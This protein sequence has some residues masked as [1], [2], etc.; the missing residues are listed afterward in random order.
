MITV[1]IIGILAAIAIP[2]FQRYLERSRYSEAHTMVSQITTSAKTYFTTNQKNCANISNC[3]EPWHQNSSRSAGMTVEWKNKV[4]PG[5]NT[6]FNT[7]GGN[8]PPQG[9]GKYKP[10]P[11]AS[12]YA[13][14]I[15]NALNLQLNDPLYFKYIHQ[16]SGSGSQAT[17]TV[18][19]RADFDPSSSDVHTHR[20]VL[21]VESG[22][23]VERPPVT[24]HSGE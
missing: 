1:A 5:A 12:S 16:P 11:S 19:A 15:A 8:P 7:N 2:A 13:Q 17:T 21:E 18:S 9:R 14:Q 10:V 22:R 3:S 23:V 24:L 20:Q 6:A 4:F